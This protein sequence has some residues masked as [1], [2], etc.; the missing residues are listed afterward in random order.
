MK[1]FC[2]VDFATNKDT[3]NVPIDTN[4]ETL[5]ETNAIVSIIDITTEYNT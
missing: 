2:E 1:L 3:T 4:K 5:P